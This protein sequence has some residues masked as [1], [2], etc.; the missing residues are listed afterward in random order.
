MWHQ[1][2][3]TAI[4]RMST[5][6]ERCC[7]QV[8]FQVRR[9]RVLEHTWRHMQ[10]KRPRLASSTTRKQNNA[11]GFHS[12]PCAAMVF[13][14]VFSSFAPHRSARV[15][16]AWALPAPSGPRMGRQK[17]PSHPQFVTSFENLETDRRRNGSEH[18]GQ[19]NDH[20]LKMCCPTSQPRFSSPSSGWPL[21]S[22][23]GE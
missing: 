14:I 8:L 23:L 5:L 16:V 7:K 21:T 3:E 15:K 19:P 6:S 12:I 22:S 18:K 17:D 11:E 2:N 20:N 9:E 13:L 1:Q 10:L 4:V